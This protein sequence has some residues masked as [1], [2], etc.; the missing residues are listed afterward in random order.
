MMQK[1]KAY[2]DGEV[3]V[4]YVGPLRHNKTARQR[5]DEACR[6]AQ[7]IIPDESGN[8]NHGVNHGATRLQVCA[9]DKETP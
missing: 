3:I 6:M 1:D 5:Y 7:D 2:F 9:H 4:V 8:G